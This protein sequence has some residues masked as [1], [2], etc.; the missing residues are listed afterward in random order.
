MD[1]MSRWDIDAVDVGVFG[2]CGSTAPSELPEE[3]E[4]R[5]YVV[6]ELAVEGDP[7]T[8]YSAARESRCFLSGW[9]GMVR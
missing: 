6:D 9:H 4:P 3:A 7:V 5:P 8:A 2:R 1:P